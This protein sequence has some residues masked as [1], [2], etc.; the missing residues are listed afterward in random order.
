M[1]YNQIVRKGILVKSR[2]QY[3]ALCSQ[4]LQLVV[5]TSV[6]RRL[7]TRCLRHIGVHRNLKGQC[8]IFQLFRKSFSKNR[9][10]RCCTIYIGHILMLVHIASLNIILFQIKGILSCIDIICSVK[11]GTAYNRAFRRIPRPAVGS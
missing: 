10:F 3:K 4:A 5:G 6:Y 11:L 9:P 7:H 8:C 2:R 1:I